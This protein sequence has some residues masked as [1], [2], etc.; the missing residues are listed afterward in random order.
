MMDRQPLMIV[1]TPPPTPNGRLHI[2]HVA[3]PYLRA[4]MYTRL[5]RM[6]TGRQ[7][8]HISHLDTYQSY[9]PKKARELKRETEEFLDDISRGIKQDFANFEIRHDHFGD[10]QST[11]Y[12]RFLDT[13][14]SWAIPALTTSSATPKACRD[15]HRSLYESNLKG[16]CRHCLH[17]VF[18]NVCENCCVPQ[19]YEEMLNPR[20][21]ACGCEEYVQP[22][23]KS[24]KTLVISQE[25]VNRI[26][27]RVLPLAGGNRRV[28]SLYQRL[29][30]HLMPLTYDAEYGVA[31]QNL[32]GKLNPWVE[33]FF[34]HLYGILS[35]C[36][37][38]TTQPVES[39]V[40]QLKQFELPP[41]IVYFFGVDN[42]YYYSF[43]FPYL[44]ERLGI[45]CMLP[46]ALKPSF[47]LLLNDAKI[48][49]SRNNVMWAKDLLNEGE[50]AA[51]R[52][53][54]AFCCPEF[55]A[56]NYGTTASRKPEEAN[57][58]GDAT[59]GY[60]S[61]RAL[62]YSLESLTDPQ[63]FSIEGLLG[64]LDKGRSYSAFLQNSGS[65]GEA[66]AMTSWLRT[67]CDTLA[68]A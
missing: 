14:I 46:A 26:K 37:I 51:L 2:G 31:V 11:A 67:V 5:L 13:A 48:S 66:A 20:C 52:N 64:I 6:T 68:I 55:S 39:A 32:P 1:V 38:D 18:Q 63:R 57:H 58:S 10:N 40:A 29:S 15:C 65:E 41:E 7:V 19:S 50:V 47:F 42:S 4:D 12:R 21:D 60:Q 49:S 43:L 34:G 33:I 3:G 36:G 44:A 9:V 22:S 23:G 17:D 54:L 59:D 28:E 25:D 30:H 61:L 8:S 24:V 62:S 56:R 45:E 16:F 35:V 27:A 53:N